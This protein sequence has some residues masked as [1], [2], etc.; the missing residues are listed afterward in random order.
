VR[1]CTPTASLRPNLAATILLSHRRFPAR[2]GSE[3][4]AP[5]AEASDEPVGEVGGARTRG[6]DRL[7]G[8][9]S[10]ELPDD[11]LFKEDRTT[12]AASVDGRVPYRA[13]LRSVQVTHA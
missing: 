9:A 11:L 3:G 6:S 5:R 1:S 13:P 4:A 2:G 7:H 10:Y 8:R 12:M